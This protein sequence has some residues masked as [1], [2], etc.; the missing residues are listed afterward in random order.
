MCVCLKSTT[1][2][3][4]HLASHALTKAS[5]R[6][7][8]LISLRPIKSTH[9]QSDENQGISDR[10]KKLN[11]RLKERDVKGQ[12]VYKISNTTSQGRFQNDQPTNKLS[13]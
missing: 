10:L 2:C 3:G 5:R 7:A 8:N 9:L 1:Q 13:V 6:F 4:H 11:T 12:T